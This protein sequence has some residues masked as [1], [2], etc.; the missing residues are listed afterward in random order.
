MLYEGIRRYNTIVIC[1]PPYN[2]AIFM[3]PSLIHIHYVASGVWRGFI[4]SLSILISRALT[5]T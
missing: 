1:V 4:L 3:Y 5:T 2:R